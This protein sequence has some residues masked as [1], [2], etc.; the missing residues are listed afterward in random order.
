MLANGIPIE[1]VVLTGGVIYAKDD[2]F[3]R[4][5]ANILNVRVVIL[6]GAGEGSCLGAG[7]E[8][9]YG[10]ARMEQP[11]RTLA[12]FVEAFPIG[13]KRVIEPDPDVVAV[14]RN[15]FVSWYDAKLKHYPEFGLQ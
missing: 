6:A 8:A 5:F 7:I 1:E 11:D 10:V 14:Y 9:A 15:V 2:L 3:A 13:E 4:M 12:E